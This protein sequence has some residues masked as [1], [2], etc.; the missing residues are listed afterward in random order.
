[1]FSVFEAAKLGISLELMEKKC[2]FDKIST[3]VP[4]EKRISFDSND[5]SG[6][7]SLS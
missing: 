4:D 3:F 2:G 1:M 7:H 6:F 5:A